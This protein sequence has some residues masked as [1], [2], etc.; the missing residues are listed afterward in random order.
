ME[1]LVKMR[2]RSSQLR[3][4]QLSALALPESS[5][6]RIQRFWARP[7]QPYYELAVYLATLIRLLNISKACL[8]QKLI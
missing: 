4:L 8:L 5:I 3:V 1:V 7:L 2:T 6:L